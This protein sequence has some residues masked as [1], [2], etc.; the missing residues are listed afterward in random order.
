MYVQALILSSLLS[1]SPNF[2]QK[3]WEWAHTI[4]ADNREQWYEVFEDFALDSEE[5]EA[6]IF[7]ELLRYS[8]F[9][10]SAET[11]ALLA[12]YVKGG[13]KSSNYSVGVFQM[14]PS[15][16]EE[17]E[18]A[19][20]ESPLKDEYQLYFIKGDSNDIRRRRVERIKDQK[21]QCVYLALFVHLLLEREPSLKDLPAESRI[22]YLAT[23]YNY[24]FSAS[25]PQLKERMARKTFHLDIV[26]LKNTTTYYYCELAAKHFQELISTL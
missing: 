12:L 13:V 2:P 22:K 23:A 24:R 25:L 15:F 21:W 1:L 5:C 7:P 3:E 10:D 6:I 11:A 9:Q 26:R 20:M 8:R 17:I 19:W 4:A 16:V 14:K 18:K